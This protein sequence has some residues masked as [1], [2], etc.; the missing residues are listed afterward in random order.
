MELPTVKQRVTL[1]STIDIEEANAGSVEIMGDDGAWKDEPVDD[2]RWSTDVTVLARDI[3]E[4]IWT[5][6]D[7]G[8]RVIRMLSFDENGNWRW[9]EA[10]AEVVNDQ[11]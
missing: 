8:A 4:G 10:T 5:V 2:D 7:H 6:W 9:V 11:D 3:D 1:W